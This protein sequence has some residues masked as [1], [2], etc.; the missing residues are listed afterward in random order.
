MG[1][2]DPVCARHFAGRSLGSKVSGEGDTQGIVWCSSRVGMTRKDGWYEAH[3]EER[4]ANTA[5][6]LQV[7]PKGLGSPER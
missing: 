7:V 3:K 5:P 2:S 6:H 1:I 4:G